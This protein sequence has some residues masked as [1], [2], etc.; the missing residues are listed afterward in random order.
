[1]KAW[2]SDHQVTYAD[3]DIMAE[4]LDVEQVLMLSEKLPEGVM[5]FV[6][7]LMYIG[8]EPA[9]L[10]MEGWSADKVAQ[11][12]HHDPILF[13]RPV[14]TDGQHIV[15]GPNMKRLEEILPLLKI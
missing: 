4:P 11:R 8:G 9:D 5:G 13:L 6:H 12:L 10:V 1:M 2:L 15:V 7:P 14:L 3:R